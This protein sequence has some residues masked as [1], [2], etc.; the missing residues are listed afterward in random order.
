MQTMPIAIMHPYPLVLGALSSLFNASDKFRVVH[1]CLD[2]EQLISA[3]GISHVD[4]AI[5]D[6]DA[7]VLDEH[8]QNMIRR[9]IFIRPRIKV[10]LYT[11][12]VMGDVINVLKQVG[13]A[14]IVSKKDMPEELLCA[15][16][17]I[18]LTNEF[19]L[20]ANIK[21]AESA[22]GDV[23]FGL[24][25]KEFEIIK[26]V[27]SG[28]TLAEIAELKN[29][30]LSTISTHKYNAMRKLGLNSN[31]ELLKFAYENNFF[32]SIISE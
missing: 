18:L 7:Y 22:A 13:V 3:V 24:S 27:V 1:I 28:Y 4:F 2:Y 26:L 10:V 8:V 29:R 30:S 21:E 17:Q 5:L 12:K 19:Y 11:D 14:A 16:E 9:L 31:T 25:N 23:T 6:I 32:Q 15:C 20:S